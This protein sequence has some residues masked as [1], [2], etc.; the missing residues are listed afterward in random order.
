M[1]VSGTGFDL[2][3]QYR[4]NVQRTEW[5]QEIQRCWDAVC[6]CVW[7]GHVFCV[8]GDMGGDVF[9]ALSGQ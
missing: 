1:T 6:V 9:P 4:L 3:I 5:K 2:A 7:P 8:S